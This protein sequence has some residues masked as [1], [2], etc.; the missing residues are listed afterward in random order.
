MLRRRN[1]RRHVHESERF[2]V[3]IPVSAVVDNCILE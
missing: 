3:E 1:N 2:S